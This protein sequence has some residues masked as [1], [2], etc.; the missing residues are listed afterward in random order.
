MARILELVTELVLGGASLTML[1]FA[2]DLAGEHELHIA[3]G[4]VASP[5][6]P[7]VLRARRRFPTYELPRL[8]RPL[9]ARR[10]AGAIRDLNALCRYLKPDVIHTHSSKAGVVGR[11]GAPSALTIRLHTIH[12]WGHTP[13]D[14]GWR[15]EVVVN[16]E[17]V[18]ALRTTRLIAVSRE[19][20]DEGLA[21]RIG[22]P[23][24]YAVVG[25]PV[26]MRPIE[27]DFASARELAR[28]RLGLPID[29]EVIGWVGRFSPQKDI[30]TLADVIRRLLLDRHNA[31]AALVGDGHDRE[32]IER[33]LHAE[34]VERRV[35]L[36][37]ERDD[38][39][40]L[41]PGFDALVHTSLHEGHPRVVREALAARVPV[42]SARVGGTGELAA[43]ERLGVLVQP[44]ESGAYVAALTRILDS[45]ELR[46][47]IADDALAPLRAV[48]GE[49]YRQMR[50]LYRR[51]L[52]DRGL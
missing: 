47:P 14:P 16:A 31:Y 29:A 45:A 52:G 24:Q 6:N 1:D 34:I 20:A 51:V 38:V 25:A 9:D 2:E 15:R 5:D 37:G 4:R 33:L 3:H 18:C 32:L 7:A 43:E 21:L 17:R 11:L 41:Y 30:R 36:L 19:V 10:D 23:G 26:D 22:R 49:P 8:A 40:R 35:R 44:G 27:G 39:Q 46:A 12:G 50:E 42:V 13:L 48:A 28:R